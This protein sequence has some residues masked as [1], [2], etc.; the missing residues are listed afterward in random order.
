MNKIAPATTKVNLDGE[1]DPQLRIDTMLEQCGRLDPPCVGFITRGHIL[2]F[3]PFLN[4]AFVTRLFLTKHGLL[5]GPDHPQIVT[6][7]NTLK[8]LQQRWRAVMGT[9]QQLTDW[10]TWRKMR[11]KFRD[12]QLD[13]LMRE[14]MMC[15]ADT[16]D[17]IKS[18]DPIRR[19]A[20]RGYQAWEGIYDTM[21][22]FLYQLFAIKTN[23]EEHAAAGTAPD[24]DKGHA[25]IQLVDYRHEIKFLKYTKLRRER[26]KDLFQSTATKYQRH[27]F[28]KAQLEEDKEVVETPAFQ[29][30][31]MA[32]EAEPLPD[33]EIFDQIEAIELVMR[34]EYEELRL[35]F[36]YYA[37]GGEGGS[38]FDMSIAEFTRFASDSLI[39][40]KTEH[41]DSGDIQIVFDATDDGDPEPT[42]EDDGDEDLSADEAESPKKGVG[43]GGT[44]SAGTGA[45]EEAKVEPE[46]DEDGEK[47]ISCV[48]LIIVLYFLCFFCLLL[49]ANPKTKELTSS[50]LSFISIAFSSSLSL[51]L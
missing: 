35:I 32:I 27:L 49:L 3:E 50:V 24:R 43:G 21:N 25:P 15:S 41:L 6:A 2:G 12:I 39:C 42:V 17:F 7:R 16:A 20:N 18:L 36:E 13:D 29:A 31:L 11:S 19:R 38:A 44:I 45:V 30:E 8:E 23:Q 48:V 1:I 28:E 22:T 26:I 37:A 10:D 9:A 46:L 14:M 40:K 51:F 47:F 34:T 4:C 33:N 5:V